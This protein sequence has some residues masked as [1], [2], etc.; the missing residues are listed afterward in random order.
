MAL[1]EPAYGDDLIVALQEAGIVPAHTQKVIIEAGL[2]E[3][4]QVHV[5]MVPADGQR[6][7]SVVAATA[8]AAT[9]VIDEKAAP[10]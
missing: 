8:Q 10:E 3:F 1:A 9:I 7:I 6:L 2:G 4:V 5:T